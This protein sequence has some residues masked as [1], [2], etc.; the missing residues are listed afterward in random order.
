M[1][2][3]IDSITI[4]IFTIEFVGKLI[5]NGVYFNGPKSFFRNNWNLIDFGIL[6]FSYFYLTSISS[7]YKIIK[8]LKFVKALRIIGKIPALQLALRALIIATP[9]VMNF[10]AIMGLFYLIFSVALISTFKGRLHSCK[11]IDIT[12]IEEEI[13]SKWQC[14][15]SGGN[16]MVLDY[17]FDNFGNALISLFVILNIG[18]MDILS[19]TLTSGDID[20]INSKESE[21]Y[22]IS[23]HPIWITFFMFFMIVGSFFFLNL[24]VGVVTHSF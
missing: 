10:T 9:D 13:L 7:N 14:L 8:A 1:L 11:D 4:A 16:W 5:Q 2:S 21:D 17:N 15:S 6:V 19:S 22:Y 3:S 24:F 18:W 20:F 23:N 12:I